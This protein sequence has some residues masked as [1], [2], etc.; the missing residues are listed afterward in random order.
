VSPD[1]GGAIDGPRSACGRPAGCLHP[2]D[3]VF[4][5]S[6]VLEPRQ[7]R[8]PFLD[9]AAAAGVL[10]SHLRTSS[11]T[12]DSGRKRQHWSV[13]AKSGENHD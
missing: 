1:A 13:A 11:K 6:G 8:L 4:V 10:H 9:G 5:A 7:R 2:R 12:T 3:L